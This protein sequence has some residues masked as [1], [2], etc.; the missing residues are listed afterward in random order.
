MLLGASGPSR[1]GLRCFSPRRPPSPRTAAPPDQDVAPS[2]PDDPE[3]KD[4]QGNVLLIGR[5]DTE[6]NV[7]DL[8]V[9]AASRKEFVAPAIDAV[10]GVEVLAGASGTASRS[11]FR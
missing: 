11:R 8:H 5:I 2:Y 3:K 7:S 10:R 6:G 4:R 1:S 9:F